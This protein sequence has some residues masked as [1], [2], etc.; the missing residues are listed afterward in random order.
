MDVFV[1]A[2]VCMC[3]CP[4]ANK[5]VCEEIIVW[6]MKSRQLLWL[7]HVAK[8][9]GDKECIQN[10]GWKTSRKM[11]TENTKEETGR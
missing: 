9:E 6:I 8:M 5:P 11:V 3:V 10:F 7:G 4:H 2:C 1:F